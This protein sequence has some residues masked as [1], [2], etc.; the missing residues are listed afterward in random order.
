MHG[1]LVKTPYHKGL[2]NYNFIVTYLLVCQ[3][4]SPLSHLILPNT[5]LCI[6]AAE[7]R[8]LASH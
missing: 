5:P 4:L 7:S 6:H 2:L 8:K 3:S 1:G